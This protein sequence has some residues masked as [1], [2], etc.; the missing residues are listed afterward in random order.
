LGNLNDN[1]KSIDFNKLDLKK[2]P[3][4]EQYMLHQLYELNQSFIRNFKSYNF[5]TLYKDLLIFCTVD[6]SAFYFDIRKDTLYC[7]PKISEKRKSCIQVLEIILDSL[8]SWFAPILSFTTEEI[9]KLINKEKNKS[10]H[11]KQFVKIPTSW[12][13]EKLNEKWKTIKKIREVSNIS[14]ESK[15]S[16][17][18]IGSS[19]EAQIKIKLNKELYEIAKNY[20]FAEICI[21]SGSEIS[22]DNNSNN[23]IKVETFKAEGEKCKVCWKINKVKC[24][25]HG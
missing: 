13:N 18:L 25:R 6:L 9:F 11:L 24:E 12:R 21:T 14:I 23:E 17:K 7:D 3:D 10:I 22:I 2:L 16:E 1:F 20:D 4:L 8:L 15:R 19:L 5:H